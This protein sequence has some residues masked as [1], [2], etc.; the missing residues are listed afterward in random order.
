M[1]ASTVWWLGLPEGQRFGPA[2][3]GRDPLNSL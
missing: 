3:M 2:E 1:N